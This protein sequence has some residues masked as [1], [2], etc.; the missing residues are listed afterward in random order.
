MDF[1]KIINEM[2]SVFK[3]I[4]YGIEHT[5]RV[6]CNANFI[7]DGE[8]VCA[9]IRNIVTLAAILH[10]IG[11]IEAQKKNGSMDGHFQELEGPPIVRSILEQAGL[12]GELIERVCYIV[13]NHHT[14]EK[15]DGLDFQIVWES[16]LLDSL[17]YGDKTIDPTSLR[18]KVIKNFS[19]IT[20]CNLAFNRLKIIGPSD[21]PPKMATG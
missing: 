19:T 15:I 20:G 12:P 5:D 17:Q 7:M 14:P 6:L 9:E 21:L 11:A 3:E 1:Q 16:D 8:A 18:L 10:D 13:G 2:K 4:P